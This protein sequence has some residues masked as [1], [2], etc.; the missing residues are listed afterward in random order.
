LAAKSESCPPKQA[1]ARWVGVG[2]RTHMFY[3]YVICSVNDPDKKY[4]GYTQDLK[5]RLLEHNNGGIR[6]TTKYKPWEL[7]VYLSFKNE[8]NAVAF[9]Q[10]L[11]SGSGRAF[12]DKRLL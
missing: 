1:T 2:G 11:K 7:I 6:H 5:R 3:V 4:V 9:E 10:Y 8:K 12:R